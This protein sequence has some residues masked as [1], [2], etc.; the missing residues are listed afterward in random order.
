MGGVLL[1]VSLLC[2]LPAPT[3]L[4]WKVAIG[5]TEYG[6]LLAGLS[7]GAALLLGLRPRGRDLGFGLCLTAGVLA[8]TPLLR[9]VR[10]ATGLPD[11]VATAF[12]AGAARVEGSDR[13]SATPLSPVTL[14]RGFD[15]EEVDP[16][17]LCYREVAGERLCLD[18]Y[19]A[20][21]AQ[22]APLVLVVHGGS[23]S[24]GTN[25]DF[26]P[27]DRALSSQGYAVADMLYRLAPRWPYPAASDDLRAALD[28]LSVHADSLGIDARRIAL[29]GRSAGAQIAMDVAYRRPD[30]RVRG[31]I[32]FYGPSDL[33]WSWAHPKDPRV[34][35]IR[36]VLTRFLGGSPEEFGPR[37]DAASP[38]HF[39]SPESPPTL[40]LHGTRDELVDAYHGEQLARRLKGAGVAH[41]FV[42]L[43]WATHGFDYVPHGPG[44]Q[45]S[46]YAIDRFL[47]AVLEEPRQ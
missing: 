24:G 7:F 38:I 5:A 11:A 16:A 28:Y 12:P 15:V 20:R 19:P 36:A 4:L 35:D 8:T 32:S 41:L 6:H 18:F 33:R 23:W 40:I 37:F 47:A 1:A 9:A 14:L 13:A 31:V 42:E 44:G 26:V 43:P 17:E 30:P 34:I 25:T 3:N 21:G 39:V 27:F 10:V 22:R 45:I 46:R 2:T 29:L